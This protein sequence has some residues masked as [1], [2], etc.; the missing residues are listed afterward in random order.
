MGLVDLKKSATKNFSAIKNAKGDFKSLVCLVFAILFAVGGIVGGLY[1]GIYLMLYGGIIGFIEALQLVAAGG[2]ATACASLF[3]ISII[4]V[5]FCVPAGILTFL[6]C[7]VIA[8]LFTA[9]F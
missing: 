9:G 7:E 2:L 1:V 4:K 3:A 8:S 5:A 6:G